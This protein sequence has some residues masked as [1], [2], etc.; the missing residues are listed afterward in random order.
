MIFSR[1]KLN[2][3]KKKKLFVEVLSVSMKYKLFQQHTFT[4]LKKEKGKKI[5]VCLVTNFM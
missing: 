2:I 4:F 1:S 3:L 5:Q